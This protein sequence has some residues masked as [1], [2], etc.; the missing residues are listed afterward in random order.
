MRYKVAIVLFYL[1]VAAG[2]ATTFLYISDKR[3][4]YSELQSALIWMLI[5][6]VSSGVLLVGEFK[7]K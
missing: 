6:C 4:N 3:Q 5:F 1:L 2:T 7:R